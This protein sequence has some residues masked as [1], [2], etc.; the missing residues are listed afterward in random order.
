M[1]LKKKKK[2]IETEPSWTK[3]T[4]AISMFTYLYI[5]YVWL[6]IEQQTYGHLAYTS[7]MQK[8]MASFRQEYQHFNL[9]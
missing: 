6:C 8:E 9:N 7:Q 4:E 2:K 3:Q 5:I 1:K